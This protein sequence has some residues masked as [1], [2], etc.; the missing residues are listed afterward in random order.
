[1]RRALPAAAGR[2]LR[3]RCRGDAP[4]A[5][6]G[7]RTPGTPGTP[8][9]IAVPGVSPLPC[10]GSGSRPGAEGA[11]PQPAE[12]PRAGAFCAVLFLALSHRGQLSVPQL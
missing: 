11:G 10:V 3:G 4:G 6:S 2:Q 7:P 9:P 8:E 1:M 12:P 5:R